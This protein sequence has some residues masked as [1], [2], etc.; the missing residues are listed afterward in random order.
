MIANNNSWTTTVPANVPSGNYL[1]RFETIALHSMPAVRHL[2]FPNHRDQLTRIPVNSNFTPNARRSKSL[3]VAAVPL[4]RLS[5]SHSPARISRPIPV[6]RFTPSFFR[7]MQFNPVTW[8]S[9]NRPLLERRQN[10][11]DIRDPWPTALRQWR[12]GQQPR[13]LCTRFCT[14]SLKSFQRTYSKFPIFRVNQHNRQPLRPQRRPKS[15]QLHSTASAAVKGGQ[16]PLHASRRG[17]ARS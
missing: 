2:F 3:A 10:S 4:L 6:V 16:A 13:I 14:P 5:S 1:I 7:F 17:R 9:D 12:L 11:D 15:A 8:Y